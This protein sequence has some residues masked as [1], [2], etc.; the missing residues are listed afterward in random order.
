MKKHLGNNLGLKLL[1]VFVAI[2]IWL[3]VVNVDDPEKTKAFVI[4]EQR[5]QMTNVEEAQARAEQNQDGKKVYSVVRDDDESGNVTVYVTARRS[6]LDKITSADITVSAN[7][8]N[9]TLQNT[10]PYEVTVPGVKRENVQCFPVAMRF[11]LEDKSEKTYA[12]SLSTSGQPASG[13]ELG[14]VKIREGENIIIAGPTSITKT[15]D[16]VGVQVDVNNLSENKTVTGDVVITDRN[17]NNLSKTQMDSLEIK[18]SKGA[19]IK[20]NE[21]N[22]VVTLWKVQ[23]NI[24]LNYS[25]YLVDD[26]VIIADPEQLRRVIN[27]IVGNSVKYM[28][29]DPGII[30]I[31]LRD[32]GDFIQVEIE[33]NG[34]GINQK[35]IPRIFDRFYRTDA[36]RNSSKGGSGIGLSIV[37]KIIEEHGG[38]IWATSR[39]GTGTTM[40]FVLRKYQEVPVHE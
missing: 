1:S 17:G 35:D 7:M 33:D 27:N 3:M 5:I 25:N 9:M 40:Y 4:P 2:L 12:I 13:Y 29:K 18:T 31:R 16:K 15:I 39:E 10:V 11:V 32:V 23:Q 34:R 19:L 28:D 37:K 20:D 22:A 8:Q 30:S 6:V 14:D 21:V 24:R 38:K 36:S 26:A